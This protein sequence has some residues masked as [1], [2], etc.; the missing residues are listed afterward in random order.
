MNI[1]KVQQVYHRNMEMSHIDE[2]LFLKNLIS[3]QQ[4]VRFT[5][6]GAKRKIAKYHSNNVVQCRR[7][8]NYE[9]EMKNNETATSVKKNCSQSNESTSA[10]SYLD[11][12]HKIK[13]SQTP[14][15]LI[16]ATPVNQFTLAYNW[17][18]NKSLLHGQNQVGLN[19]EDLLQIGYKNDEYQLG[20]EEIMHKKR[21]IEGL[22]Y[23]LL[24]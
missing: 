1:K 10:S 11:V 2:T 23:E 19:L 9:A 24:K 7:A 14:V 16:Q 12:I 6:F 5:A 3:N 8:L 15:I 4:N 18:F 20:N 22:F 13:A 17:L 21:L